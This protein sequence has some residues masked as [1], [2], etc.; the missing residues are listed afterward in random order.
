MKILSVLTYYY[1][2]WTGLTA[3]AVRVAEGLANRGHEVTVLT[4]RHS[5]EL[6]R[7]EM[8]NGVRVIRL[9][10]FM[11]FSRG[12]L[13]PAFPY[14]AGKLISQ[15]DVVQIHTPLPE[16]LQVGLLCRVMRRPLLMTHHGDV[17]MPGGA[18]NRAIQQLAFLMLRATGRL[19]GAVTSYSRD[20]A[21]HSRLLSSMRRKL[22]YVYPPVK[23]PA[24]DPA[25]VA[26][27][28]AQLGLEGKTVIGFAGR[29]VREKGFDHLLKALPAIHAAYP[30][31]HLLYAGE[32]RIAY[33]RFYEQCLPLIRAEREHLTFL[34]LLRDPQQIANFYGMCDLFVLPSR[35]DMM[36]LVQVE[37]MLCGVPVVAADIPGA[38]VVVRETGFGRLAPPNSPQALARAI[39][40]TLHDR[41]LYEPSREAVRRIFNTEKTLCQYE[42]IMTRLVRRHR[43]NY[44]RA[45]ATPAPAPTHLL[46]P[47]QS[48]QSTQLPAQATAARHARRNAT[49]AWDSLTGDDHAILDRILRNE[50]DMAYRRRARILLDYLDPQPGERILDCGCGAGFYLMAIGKLRQVRLVGLDGDP[51][52][53]RQAQLE[54]VPAALVRSDIQRLPFAGESFDKV[55]M[56]EVLEHLPDDRAALREIHRILKPG[57]VLALSVPHSNYPFWWDPINRVWAGTGHEPIRSGPLVGIWTNHE[58]LYWPDEL[59]ERVQEAG[60]ATEKVEE[61]THY[62][63]PFAHFLVYGIGKPLVER[64]L[65]PDGLLK[66]ADR[67]RG[68]ENNGSLLNPI[69]LGLALFNTVDRL[70]ERPKVAK[71]ATFVNVLVK[72]RKQ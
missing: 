47:T 70:N 27:W 48:T 67:F 19:A 72:A 31:A 25:A 69:N 5:P 57:G 8:I 63:L 50:A 38:R 45:V 46:R 51:A 49:H 41:R 10:P 9:Q 54:Q 71:R 44:A 12:M 37:A 56:S 22:A 52:R 17:V 68:E 40:E 23:I 21:E 28:K 18:L 55:L 33:E 20:Y 7:D 26:A 64:S 13:T 11:R 29:W 66:S 15:H 42:Q 35:T 59:A 58:R 32:T 61:T 24:P 30:E 60:F 65:L 4:T 43:P 62:S 16:A 14:A 3:H 2:H 34:G 36:A 6:P 1:P 39:V 53:L